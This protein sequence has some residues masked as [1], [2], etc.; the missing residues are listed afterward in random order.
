M[1]RQTTDH[2]ISVAPS[3]SEVTRK[4]QGHPTEKSTMHGILEVMVI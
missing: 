2:A 3:R 4:G 1:M